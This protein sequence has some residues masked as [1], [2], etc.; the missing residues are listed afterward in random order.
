[1]KM[2]CLALFVI[3]SAG[4]I[5]LSALTPALTW[6]IE[7]DWPNDHEHKPSL[8]EKSGQVDLFT[9]IGVGFRGS[10]L[11]SLAWGDY[12]ADG[13][14]DILI[15][16]CASPVPSAVTFTYRYLNANGVFFENGTGLEGVNFC[17]V[18][19]GDYDNDA[20]LDIL[21]SGLSDT[22][23]IISRVYRNDGGA[24]ID[25]AAGL[26]P[27]WKCS[28]AWGDYDNDGDLDILLSG[29]SNFNNLIT[30][31]YRNDEGSFVDI[32]A[33]LLGLFFGTVD[34]GDY[35]ND[36]DLDILLTGTDGA[37]RYTRVYQN[38]G[39]IFADIGAGLAGVTW[40]AGAWGD[41]DGDGDLDILVT[42]AT[43]SA[44]IARVYRNDS[45]AF[46]DIGAGLPD[47]YEGSAAWGDYDND[48]DLDILLTGAASAGYI[49][50]VYRNDSGAFVDIGAGLTGVVEGPAAW[51]DYDNDGDLDILL[52]GSTGTERITK[53]YRNE[54][55]QPNT[56]PTP[57]SN[58][59]FVLL[60]SVGTFSWD[61]ATDNETSSTGLTYNLRIGTTYN[62]QEIMSSMADLDTGYRRLSELGNTN[63]SRSWTIVFPDSVPR[64]YWSV[65][66]VDGAFAG[67][68]F[69]P[70]EHFDPSGGLSGIN[71]SS[72]NTPALYKL[73]TNVPNPF[74]PLTTI[75]FEL[76]AEQAVT[77]K[78][79]DVAGRLVDT[80]L[81]N[82]IAGAGLTKIAWQG[83]DGDGR[84]VPTGVYLYRLEGRGFSETKR[85]ALV[86]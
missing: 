19:W 74:N 51:G 69:A 27:L 6:G 25:I 31:V 78:V 36:G 75:A 22:G 7:D 71:D 32:E 70:V 57:P 67:S 38:S 37:V 63:Q 18:A 47:I 54:C 5:L 46:I 30:R 84:D 8:G 24:F 83:R 40:S 42:G 33:G 68:A 2:T 62:G 58:L 16:G 12:D 17:S 53:V 86:R 77:L 52:T 4:E 48:G 29:S 9:D 3:L 11:S 72:D 76:A 10:W 50:R 26:P 56:P 73:Y 80:L 15:A 82:E 79:Y 14:L 60:D 61:E 41:Y 35:D 20:D 13:D 23:E 21:L 59:S 28:S 45:G 65:Q 1:M 34:W 55:I 64:F 39:G 44:H 85:M 43:D 81:D 49:S 66:A